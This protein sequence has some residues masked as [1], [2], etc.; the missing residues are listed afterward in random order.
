[1]GR[2]YHKLLS[3]PAH[4]LCPTKPTPPSIRTTRLSDDD[5]SWCA[6]RSVVLHLATVPPRVAVLAP[7]AD[8][9]DGE[10]VMTNFRSWGLGDPR[11]DTDL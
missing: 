1:M 8:A 11:E 7:M 5:S 4:V 3:S 6:N 2:Y 9:E 10:L